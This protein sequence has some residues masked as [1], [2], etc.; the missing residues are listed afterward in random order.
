MQHIFT[1]LPTFH[2]LCEEGD[3]L[4]QEDQELLAQA[5]VQ[6]ILHLERR[7]THLHWCE[8]DIINRDLHIILAY[9]TKLIINLDI[10]IS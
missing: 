4:G 2:G 3:G 8:V 9:C 6:L 10:H 1:L 5:R 7:Q